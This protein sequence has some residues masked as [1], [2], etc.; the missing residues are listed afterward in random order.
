MGSN[1]TDFHSSAPA[2][3]VIRNGVM[4]SVRTMPRPRNARLS[5]SAIS[6][7]STI[8]IATAPRVSRIE[9]SATPRNCESVNTVA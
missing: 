1:S 7:P 4:I 2:T 9:F 5:S 6:S 8:A 3:G